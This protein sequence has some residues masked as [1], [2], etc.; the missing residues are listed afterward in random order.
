MLGLDLWKRGTISKAYRFALKE[1]D[2]F[3]KHL[4][5]MLDTLLKKHNKILV[6]DIHSYNHRRGGKNAPFDDP[7]Q[8]PDINLGTET[9]PNKKEWNKTINACKDIFSSHNVG[10]RLLDVR[11]N[12]KFKGGAMARWIHKNY[13]QNV[14]CISVEFKKIF[15]NEWSGEPFEDS[16]EDIREMVK[17]FIEYYSKQQI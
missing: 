3:Y 10:G 13:P 7:V 2:L 4:K 12:I 14:C 15:M 6:L 11:E 9:I 5:I 8:N 16:I 17:T 1:Y